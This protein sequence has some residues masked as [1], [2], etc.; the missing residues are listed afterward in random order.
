MCERSDPTSKAACG[1][2]ITGFVAGSE[3]AQDAAVVRRVADGVVGG[4]IAPTDSAMEAAAT[5]L[6]DESRLFCIRSHW[7]AGYVGAIVV[8]YGREHPEALGE[9]TADHLLKILERAFPCG[10]RE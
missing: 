8:Q 1:A 7:T 3:A 10:E 9:R 6:R 5:K 4:T 2:Y